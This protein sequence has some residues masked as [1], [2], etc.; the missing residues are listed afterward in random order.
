MDLQIHLDISR[1]FGDSV[2]DIVCICISRFK[3]Y[4]SSLIGS[5]RLS[6]AHQSMM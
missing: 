2:V 1:D 4:A 3:Q 5:D 6:G